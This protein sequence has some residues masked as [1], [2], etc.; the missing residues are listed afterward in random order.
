MAAEIVSLG[1]SCVIAY[2]L[3]NFKMRQR[4]FP[5]DHAK[6]TISQIIEVL[7]K[8]FYGYN[9][10]VF[11]KMSS[12]H[13]LIKET[14]K[15]DNISFELDKSNLPSC[16]L[17]NSYKITFAHE[18]AN[19]GDIDVLKQKMEKRCERMRQ[20]IKI[21]RDKF[22]GIRIE[23]SP[24]KESKESIENY[25]FQLNELCK[26]IPR[27]IL[28]L[29]ISYKIANIETNEKIIKIHYY[30]EFSEDWKMSFIDWQSVFI[31]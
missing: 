27:I 12:N 4:A 20:L 14:E 16:I 28:I 7:K 29:H 26:F 3:H 17:T 30:S 2:Q 9:D 23:L 21:D 11:K 15:E 19:T 6:T 22:I 18:L 25:I 13:P 10:F 1:G 5:F 8:D 31:I 24:L